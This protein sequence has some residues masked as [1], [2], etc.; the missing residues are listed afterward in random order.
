MRKAYEQMLKI[1]KKGGTQ[2]EIDR[3]IGNEIDKYFYE[4]KKA[5]VITHGRNWGK[6]SDHEKKY[7]L[8]I[9][10]RGDYM[11]V[12]YNP[13]IA[14]CFPP[15]SN[16]HRKFNKNDFRHFCAYG[17]FVKKENGYGKGLSALDLPYTTLYAY[18]LNN[19]SYTI[20]LNDKNA[21]TLSPG[22]DLYKA[23][24][25]H[26]KSSSRATGPYFEGQTHQKNLTTAQ[27]NSIKNFNNYDK[28][29]KETEAYN[30]L[31]ISEYA[32][33]LYDNQNIIKE[34]FISEINRKV[35]LIGSISFF[36]KVKDSG[37]M[38]LINNKNKLLFKLKTNKILSKLSFNLSPTIA[39]QKIKFTKRQ[40]NN[41]LIVSSERI[42]T[43]QKR[44][45]VEVLDTLL[46]KALQSYVKYTILNPLDID[47]RSNYLTDKINEFK[48][49]TYEVCIRNILF[50]AAITNET[51]NIFLTCHNL[52]SAKKALING[53][54]YSLLGIVNLAEI[55][56]WSQIKG[57]SIYVSA[58]FDDINYMQ[59]ARHFAFKFKTSF[60]TELFEFKCE[61]LDNKA[62]KIEFNDGE[63]K[64]P[65]IDLQIDISK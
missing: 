18:T 30:L 34:T 46:V 63:D 37:E 48:G 1:S 25:E 38:S 49:F 47:I 2:A 51:Q 6:L 10:D 23:A 16:F 62:K 57:R 56:N 26:E 58:K 24:Y 9:I 27:M 35:S 53:K 33:F 20:K 8:L 17:T 12:N 15:N 43:G 31:S 4:K 19:Y 21:Y 3:A 60:P 39:S 45:M 32:Y 29:A 64:V 7:A 11:R 13:N 65:I 44:K 22:L 14:L 52:N 50:S 41:I 5:L 54:I 28:M 61:L 55:K 59:N 36:D 40:I 42:K